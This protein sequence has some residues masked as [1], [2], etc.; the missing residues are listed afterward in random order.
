[1]SYTRILHGVFVRALYRN[2]RSTEKAYARIDIVDD[3][4]KP[5][6]V[7]HLS[8]TYDQYKI[9]KEKKKLQQRIWFEIVD[10]ERDGKGRVKQA[11]A[12]FVE[13][14]KY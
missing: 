9:F 12:Q 7:W 10:M 4:K 3:L 14:Y 6:N 8:V 11:F 5:V 13:D 2:L 1:M